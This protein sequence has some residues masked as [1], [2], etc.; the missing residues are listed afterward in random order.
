MFNTSQ[1]QAGT[2]QSGMVAVDM[3]TG[4]DADT[5]RSPEG[6]PSELFVGAPVVA[7]NLTVTFDS[8]KPGHFLA[9]GPTFCGNLVVADIGLGEWRATETTSLSSG[10]GTKERTLRVLRQPKL[11]LIPTLEDVADRRKTQFTQAPALHLTKREGHKFSHGHAV[12]LTGEQGTTGAARLVARGRC[13]L[14]QGS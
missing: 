13:V 10:D 5:G 6:Y 7:A 9:D 12:I 1:D 4:L 2:G 14:V 11:E 3:P 8:T